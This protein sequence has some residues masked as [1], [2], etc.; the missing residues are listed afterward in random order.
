MLDS[1]H[2][3]KIEGRKLKVFSQQGIARI[4]VI[5]CVKKDIRYSGVC[6]VLQFCLVDKIN[7][8]KQTNK[9]QNR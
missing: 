7:K 2:E 1:D 3:I 9:Q 4:T 5:G 8:S 6:L